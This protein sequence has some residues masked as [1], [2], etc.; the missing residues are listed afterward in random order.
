MFKK[1]REKRRVARYEKS[2]DNGFNWVVKSYFLESQPLGF[3]EDQ[4]F[5]DGS[6]FDNGALQAVRKIRYHTNEV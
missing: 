3:I 2:F 6:G 5:G 1:W 4:I